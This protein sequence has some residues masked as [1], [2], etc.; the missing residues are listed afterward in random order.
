MT[1]YEIIRKNI[2]N[3]IVN[4]KAIGKGNGKPQKQ[5]EDDIIA[6]CMRDFANQETD[7]LVKKIEALQRFKYNLSEEVATLRQRLMDAGLEK[8][9]IITD[10]SHTA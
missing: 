8:P 10:F 2:P 3:G 5:A 4:I 6:K 9:A 7:E 1:E